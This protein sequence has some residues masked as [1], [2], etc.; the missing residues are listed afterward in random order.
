MVS[1]SA[2][3]HDGICMRVRAAR[4][5]PRDGTSRLPSAIGDVL[6]EEI[7][8]NGGHLRTS[9]HGRDPTARARNYRLFVDPRHMVERDG[10]MGLALFFDW[11]KTSSLYS[12]VTSLN[13]RSLL[14]P[15]DWSEIESDDPTRSPLTMPWIEWRNIRM[16]DGRI[17]PWTNAALHG[18]PGWQNEY[19]GRDW[20]D[21]VPVNVEHM[22]DPRLGR[23]CQYIFVPDMSGYEGLGIAEQTVGADVLKKTITILVYSPA[24]PTGAAALLEKL[25]MPKVNIRTPLL[26]SPLF[27]PYATKGAPIARG[28]SMEMT[29]RSGG[30]AKNY[31]IPEL[32]N[33]TIYK[34]TTGG[35]IEQGVIPNG[36]S[37]S[38][39]RQEPSCIFTLYPTALP[40]TNIQ[41]RR[42]F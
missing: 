36:F 34:V 18:F 24:D 12:T 26:D 14:A 35:T 15:I 25:Q 21:G 31:D 5:V 32:P 27:Q 9:V 22:Y 37:P 28:F 16:P 40:N 11:N 20:L 3:S 38:F 39:W 2:L 41:G 33:D 30:G 7:I 8:G 29:S 19:R 4:L 17:V 42:D 13:G 10:L 1:T 23:V 6:F